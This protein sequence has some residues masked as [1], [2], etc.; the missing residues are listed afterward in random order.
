MKLQALVELAAAKCPSKPERLAQDV[1][2]RSGLRKSLTLRQIIRLKRRIFVTDQRDSNPTFAMLTP[3]ST[4][5]LS[6]L[7]CESLPALRVKGRKGLSVKLQAPVE[8][9]QD[10]R[11]SYEYLS[12]TFL[13]VYMIRSFTATISRELHCYSSSLIRAFFHSNFSVMKRSYLPHQR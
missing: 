13:C 12:C 10:V 11:L 5:T 4:T 6:V 8:L 7:P 1:R 3:T 2:L 9:E